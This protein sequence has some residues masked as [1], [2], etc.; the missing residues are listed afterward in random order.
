MLKI[1]PKA[2]IYNNFMEIILFQVINNIE[3]TLEVLNSIIK[4]HH[5]WSL[6]ILTLGIIECNKNKDIVDSY[7]RQHAHY[8][9]WLMHQASDSIMCSDSRKMIIQTH[10]KMH[11]EVKNL[12]LAIQKNR[13]D[14]D[15]IHAYHAAN[16][17]FIAAIDDH[18]TKL[19]TYL[20]QLDTLTGLPLRA[21]FYEDVELRVGQSQLNE[22]NVYLLILDIDNFK[23]INDTYGH[24]IGDEVLSTVA[25]R[26]RAGMRSSETLYRVG[27]EEFIALFDTSSDREAKSVASR[28]CGLLS[29]TPVIISTGFQLDVTVT[30][31]L[32]LITEKELLSDALE[33]ADKAMYRGKQAGR[34]CCFIAKD[35]GQLHD[36]GTCCK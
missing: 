13:V 4:E 33:R 16:C 5:D 17:L 6:K 9:H 21:L 29:R 7:T 31:G 25:Q 36:I 35:T 22:H 20:N 19:I 8:H 11:R 1:Q 26:L 18:K 28:I 15:I 3:L 2:L 30:G 12:L 24:N 34:D 23:S 32:T 27:G 14:T 10:E